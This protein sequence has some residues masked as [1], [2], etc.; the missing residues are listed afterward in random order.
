MAATIRLKL[1][2]SKKRPFYR[3]VAADSRRARDGRFIETLGFYNPI[4]QPAEVKVDE[5]LIF[6]WFERGAVI[7]TS[8]ASLLRR[9]GYLQKWELMKQGVTGDL[10]ETRMEAIRSKQQ[11]RIERIDQAKKQSKSKKALAK[12]AADKE[13]SKSEAAEAAK[14]EAA[15]AAEEVPAEG[16]A[17]EPTV[18]EAPAVEVSAAEAPAEEAMVE[19]VEEDPLKE[20]PGA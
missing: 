12:A 18:D 11:A 6:K 7:T 13:A 14:V 16:Q 3:L 19:S 8:A 10:L 15:P 5:T 2:G 20:S 4:T 17:V 9:E 1:M